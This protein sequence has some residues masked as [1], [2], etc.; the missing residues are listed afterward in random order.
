MKIMHFFEFDQLAVVMM[1]LIGIITISV[2]FFSRRYLKGDTQ[3]KHFYLLLT[4][5]L[6]SLFIMVSANHILLL[7]SSWLASNLILT[8]LMIHKSTWRAAYRSGILATKNFILGFIMIGCAFSLLHY[9]SGELSLQ[10]LIRFNYDFFIRT[11]AISLLFLGAMTQSGLFPF[12]R[13]LISS[14]NSPTP[15]SAI[16]H[17][18]LVNGGGFLLCR[19]APL[20]FDMTAM[21]NIIFVLGLMTALLGTLWKLMQT[22]V[23]RM[24]ACST[25]G[26]MGFMIM[27]CGLGLFPAA[28][29]HLCWHGFF[30][31]Y[32]FMAS[33][34][35]AQEKRLDL[36]YPPT[37]LTFALS[38]LCGVSG[39]IAFAFISHKELFANDT[40][41]ILIFIAFISGSQ[42][43][44]SILRRK[45]LTLFLLAFIT[46]ACAGGMYGLSVHLIEEIIAPLHLT[47][48]QPLTIIHKAGI[49]LFAGSWLV[50]LFSRNSNKPTPNW[51]LKTYVWMLNA[52]QPHPRTITTHRNHYQY[53]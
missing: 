16:M 34:S 10:N 21:L 23:K 37:F 6:I 14:L 51:M 27:Q 29:A 36:D 12:H 38:L 39:S 53:L 26:Q 30:K 33:G 24:L 19:L 8:I 18:G 52:S 47:Q 42:F 44:I 7:L 45:P 1:S 48:V 11:V 41:L 43:A 5:L 50:I 49:M 25:M 20:Y 13:W 4:A 9:V 3:Y 40:T 15:V 31:A 17:A 22:D 46:T 2:G 35:S 32:L 28:L